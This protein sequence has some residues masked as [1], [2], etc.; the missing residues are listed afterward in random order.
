MDWMAPNLTGRLHHSR[1][2]AREAEPTEDAIEDIAE[3]RR[4]VT[5]VDA[6]VDLSD[7]AIKLAALEN[8]L[9]LAETQLAIDRKR[10]AIEIEVSRILEAHAA[11]EAMEAREK[12]RR[13]KELQDEEEM[14]VLMLF[15]S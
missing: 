14:I 8:A 1:G 10:Q 13:Q 3:A 4:T 9:S 11:H 2:A 5:F 12:T 6:P 15:A 7:L